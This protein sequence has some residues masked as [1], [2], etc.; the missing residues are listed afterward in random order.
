MVD[1]GCKVEGRG[2]EGVLD[3]EVEEDCV[4][5]GGVGACWGGGEGYVPGAEG[6]I[7][8]EGDSEAFGGVLGDFRVFL[9]VGWLVSGGCLR[10][11]GGS[12]FLDAFVG[13]VEWILIQS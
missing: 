13:H 1:A 3:R 4:A 9:L 8:G 12:D 10:G 11:T 6:I 5:P 7:R 2:L